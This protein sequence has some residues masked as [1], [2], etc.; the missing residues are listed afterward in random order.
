V[1]SAASKALPD[2]DSKNMSSIPPSLITDLRG[3]ESDPEY[4][5]SSRVFDPETAQIYKQIVG[6]HV[7]SIAMERIIPPVSSRY[8]FYVNDVTSVTG[9]DR[10]EV[11]TGTADLALAPESHSRTV[12]AW[13]FGS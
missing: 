11:E 9:H 8:R 1:N 13:I 10:Q 2:L 4:E 3:G 5:T 12:N 6:I 7:D